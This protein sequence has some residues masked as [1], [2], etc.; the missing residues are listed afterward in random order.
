MLT[1][2]SEINPR[3]V[4]RTCAHAAVVWEENMDIQC[5]TEQWERGCAP[6]TSIK[7][8]HSQLAAKDYVYLRV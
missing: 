3:S 1:L 2:I 4:S 7:V 8:H 5:S 6:M